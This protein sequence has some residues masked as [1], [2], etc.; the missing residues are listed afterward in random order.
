MLVLS[1]KMTFCQLTHQC[2]RALSLLNCQETTCPLG[3]HLLGAVEEV[4]PS[5]WY[6]R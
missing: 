2:F 4:I 5:V 6:Y 3:L 1:A